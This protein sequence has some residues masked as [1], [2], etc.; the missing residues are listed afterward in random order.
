MA[1]L[2][3]QIYTYAS[4]PY[5]DWHTKAWGSAL[6]LIAVIGVLS[7]LTRLATRQRT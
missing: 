2:P 6:I 5:A 4:S 3:L 7:L 1:A